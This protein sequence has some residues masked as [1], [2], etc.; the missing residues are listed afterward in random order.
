MNIQVELYSKSGINVS[1]SIFSKYTIRVEEK[2]SFVYLE[3]AKL[4]VKNG[5]IVVDKANETFELPVALINSIILGAGT[6]ITHDVFKIASKYNCIIN[7]VGNEGLFFYSTCLNT[8]HSNE[9]LTKQIFMYY[10][11]KERLKVVNTLMSYR[12]KDIDLKNKTIEQIRGME[13]IRVRE[14]YNEMSTKY[15][16]KWNGRKSFGFEIYELDDVNRYIT[17][18]NKFMYGVLN[19][20]ILSFGYSPLLGFIH[21]N[22]PLAFTY[23]LADVFKKE[24]SIESAFKLTSENKTFNEEFAISYFKEILNEK[25]I[26]KRSTA[27]LNELL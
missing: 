24:V 21:E 2:Q 13:G 5:C 18:F 1:K 11:Q 22:S 16:V 17:L 26:L 6:S 3:H 20:V 27:F 9:N 12:F 10:D 19:S 25:N 4:T 23:D 8:V 7:F 15:N 14:V